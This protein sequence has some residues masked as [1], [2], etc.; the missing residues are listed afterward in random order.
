VLSFTPPRQLRRS[1]SHFYIEADMDSRPYKLSYGYDAFDHLT[2][3]TGRVWNAQAT[4]DIGIGVYA[5]EK[6]TSWLYDVDGRLTSSN[7]VQYAFDAA[8]RVV[9]VFG[10]GGDLTQSQVFDGDGQR[11]KLLSQQVIHHEDNSTTTDTKTQ[12]FIISSVL[13]KVIT[14]LNE[15]GQ[16]TRTYVY[17]GAEVLAWQQKYNSTESILWEHR[18]ASNASY[19]TT[20]NQ[21]MAGVSIEGKSSELDPFGADSGTT[22]P[23]LITP[24]LPDEGGNNAIMAYPSFG[25]LRHL[26]MSYSFAGYPLVKRRCLILP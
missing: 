20:D 21:G 13:G 25:D 7:E 11:T 17:Q 14:E 9:S 3:R 1:A 2:S 4:A 15:S 16:K 5:N 8:G 26:G 19:R 23:Y 12:Y 6:N 24:N 10:D 18:D 22:N